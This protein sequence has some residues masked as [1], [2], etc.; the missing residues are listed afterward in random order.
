MF[1]WGRKEGRDSFLL[2]KIT[3]QITNNSL[4]FLLPNPPIISTHLPLFS[5]FWDWVDNLAGDGELFG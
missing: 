2:E 1:S 5:Y 4:R 3:Q